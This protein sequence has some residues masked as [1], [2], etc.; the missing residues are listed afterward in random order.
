MFC[1]DAVDFIEHACLLVERFRVTHGES[2]GFVPF[3]SLVIHEA[4]I[5]VFLRLLVGPFHVLSHN[6]CGGF[7]SFFAHEYEFPTLHGEAKCRF[8]K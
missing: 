6:C 3:L 1:I 7:I 4:S 5:P 2:H 8:G